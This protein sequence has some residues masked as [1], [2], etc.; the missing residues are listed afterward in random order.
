MIQEI[1]SA[2]N[3]G[4]RNAVRLK[5]SRGRKV[6][7][8]YIIFGQRETLRALAAGVVPVEVFVCLEVMSDEEWSSLQRKLP[9]AT[10]LFGLPKKLMSQ[11][12]YGDRVDGV[13]AIAERPDLSIENL[14]PGTG[15]LIVVLEGIEKPGNIGA[16]LRTMDGCGADALILA[17]PKCDVLHPNCI[18][19]SMGSVFTVPTAVGTTADVIAWCADRKISLFAAKDSATSIYTDVDLKDSVALA[20]GNEAS[21]LSDRWHGGDITELAIPMQGI[22]DSLNLSVAAG[23]ML[24]EAMRQRQGG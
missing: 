3:P 12:G 8:R 9:S 4:F 10:R 6:Q 11:L 23:I 24:Y 22:S 20:F 18:R 15:P 17:D 21:G 13:V 1:T 14:Q 2:Q 16:V 19:S 7:H 5:T